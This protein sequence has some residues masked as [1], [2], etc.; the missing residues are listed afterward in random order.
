[1]AQWSAPA[2]ATPVN[3]TSKAG[4]ICSPCSSFLPVEAYSAGIYAHI[5]TDRPILGRRGGWAIV[6]AVG[7]F[8]LQL[9][10]QRPPGQLAVG[11]VLAIGAIG[12]VAGAWMQGRSRSAAGDPMVL[13][14]SA[15]LVVCGPLGVILFILGLVP[16]A[17]TVAGCILMGTAMG[18]AYPQIT[19][20]V[21]AVSPTDQ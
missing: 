20:A 7:V 17:V 3:E 10:G 1:M 16:I 15:V 19:S 4:P 8:A 18:L 5:R 11:T 21:L 12:W 9:A 13:R 14:W 6:A 2:T